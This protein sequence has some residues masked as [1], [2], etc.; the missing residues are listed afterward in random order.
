M[1]VCCWLT[2]ATDCCQVATVTLAS[3]AVR[4]L[5]EVANVQLGIQRSEVVAGIAYEG[6]LAGMTHAA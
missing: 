2:A 5:C 4:T 1:T 3:R 6:L